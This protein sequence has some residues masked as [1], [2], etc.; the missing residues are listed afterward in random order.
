MES[1]RCRSESTQ[2]VF[3]DFDGGFLS[4]GVQG[5]LD[6]QAGLRGRAG[7]RIDDSLMAH[8]GASAPV[9]SN[10]AEESVLDLVPLA[11]ARREAADMQA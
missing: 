7:D 2:L 8:Q 5:R 1:V 3:G 9:L 4:V 6:N 11:R 10:E